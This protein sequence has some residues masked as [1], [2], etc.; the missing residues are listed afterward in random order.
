MR[1]LIIKYYKKPNGQIDEEV[2][3][4]KK[5]RMSDLQSA[6]I[7]LDFKTLS[8]S[9]SSL[10]GVQVP[11]DWDRVLG[12]YY[13]YYKSTIERLLKENG[14]EIQNATSEPTTDPN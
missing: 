2:Q 3:I 13:Q 11:R 9:K 6:S 8:V 1:Y 10:D 14:Y 7:I 12:Y 5:V 4:S